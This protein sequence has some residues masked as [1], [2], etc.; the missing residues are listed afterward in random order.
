M[1]SV[2]SNPFNLFKIPPGFIKLFS[3]LG[4]TLE[5]QRNFM[6][7][8]SIKDLEKLSGI[9]AHTIRIWEKRYN[10][11]K[12]GRTGT[13]I[14]YYCD[15]D[16]KRILNV[17]LLNRHGFK[18]SKIARLSDVQLIE[19]VVH[20]AQGADD[21][22][23]QLEQLTIAMIELDE[24]RFDKTISRAIMQIGF[25]ETV[26]KLIYPFFE[27]IGILWQTGSIN[28]AQEHFVSNLIRQKL[29]VAIDGLNHVHEPGRKNFLLFLPEGEL[30][31]L[32]LLFYHY[33]L[34]KHGHKVIYLGQSVPFDDLG[35]VAG[36]H[37]PDVLITSF[38]TSLKDTSL[39]EY[40]EKLQ[41]AFPEKKIY[42]TGLF[43]R[44]HENEI[45][46]G[47]LKLTCPGDLVR[48]MKDLL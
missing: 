37:N 6:G 35:E 43:A 8:Y 33:I 41:Q 34:R 18:I 26:I 17:S 48:K 23:S 28:P 20:L 38:T 46:P 9:K 5:V 24:D 30:H 47:I 2:C 40:M 3:A 42:V 12:P 32:G 27:K 7:K 29:L 14:R 4:V 45:P 19:N 31:E 36:I 1:L 11:V 10:I 44:E 21:H 16:L 13:N 22:E 25:E 39:K 15:D